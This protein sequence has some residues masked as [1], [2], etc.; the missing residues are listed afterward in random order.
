V[1][2]ISWLDKVT[3]VEVL[4]KVNEDSQM[5]NSVWQR[6]HRWIGHVLRHDGPLHE[7]IEGRM[8]C[9]PTRGRRI[10]MLHDIISFYRQ[11]AAKWPTASIKFT[12]RPKIRFFC[13]IGGTRCTDS[14]QTWHGQRAAASAWLCKILSQSAWGNAAPNIKIFHFLVVTPQGRTT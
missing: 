13:P 5:L 11:Y 3:N 8:K 9:K 7:I 12:H 10:Q 4:R 6:K 2:K 14:R 1:E